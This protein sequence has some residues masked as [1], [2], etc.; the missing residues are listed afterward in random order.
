MDITFFFSCFPECTTTATFSLNLYGFSFVSLFFAFFS[1]YYY[2]VPLA[3]CILFISCKSK[4]DGFVHLKMLFVISHCSKLNITRKNILLQTLLHFY[5]Y[6]RCF[7]TTAFGIKFTIHMFFCNVRGK[8]NK[9]SHRNSV[10][11]NN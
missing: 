1:F 2:V 8:K 10:L 9:K 11:G 4:L 7:S 5:D 3:T 6:I